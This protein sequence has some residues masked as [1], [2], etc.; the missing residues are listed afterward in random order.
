MLKSCAVLL[1]AILCYVVQ[2]DEW[3]EKWGEHYHNSGKVA[4]YADK[5]G[6][7]GAHSHRSILH[8][9]LACR[10]GWPV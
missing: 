8:S 7:A 9:V 1:C 4:K 2:G 5:W 6:K 10:I 3:E